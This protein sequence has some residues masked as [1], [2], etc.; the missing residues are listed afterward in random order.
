MDF[1][2]VKWLAILA[3]LG[4]V[5]VAALIDSRK[6]DTLSEA[7]WRWFR[8]HDKVPNKAAYAARGALLVFLLWLTGHFVMGWWTT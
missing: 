5:E 4:S 3:L 2:A 1:H 6:G 7:V 8:V